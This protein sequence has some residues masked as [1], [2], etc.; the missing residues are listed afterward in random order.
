MRPLAAARKIEV[1]EVASDQFVLADERRLQQIL[2]NLLGNAIK[3]N[4]EG[5]SV[6]LTCLPTSRATVRVEIKDTGRG[7]NASD[8]PGL[9][10][11][12]QRF[13]TAGE[14]IEGIGLG[15][16]ISQRLVQAMGGTIGAESEPG[17]GSVFWIELPAADGQSNREEQIAAPRIDIQKSEIND[18]KTVLYIE[19][20]LSNLTLVERVLIQRPAIKLISAQLGQLGIDL[21][22]EH[23]PAVILLDLHLP[24][25]NGDQVLTSLRSDPRTAA[26]PIIML[27]ANAVGGDMERL[28]ELGATAYVTKPLDV[29]HFLG[30]LDDVLARSK[31]PV[32]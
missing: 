29:R 27:S 18:P 4:K 15:L 24:D 6:S 23:L 20:N 8:L 5:G 26:I 28:Q 32:V 16:A 19:D 31:P 14:N 10:Q 11:P 9:F 30:V 17:V 1:A 7:I 25:M 13:Q 21:A 22:S 3:Y 2:L 12:F